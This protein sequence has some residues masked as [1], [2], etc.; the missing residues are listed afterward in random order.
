MNKTDEIIKLLKFAETAS[1]GDAKKI[2]KEIAEKVGC[3]LQH[4]YACKR[5][6]RKG[7]RI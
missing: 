2:N 5:D 4:I 6:L 7:R 3:S 1:S